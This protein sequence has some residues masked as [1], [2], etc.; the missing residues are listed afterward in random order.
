MRSSN[1]LLSLIREHLVNPAPTGQQF[2]SAS[3]PSRNV[4]RPEARVVMTPWPLAVGELDAGQAR[5]SGAQKKRPQ[6]EAGGRFKG[7]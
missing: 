6:G 2:R 7:P 3:P 1:E 5:R 4:L